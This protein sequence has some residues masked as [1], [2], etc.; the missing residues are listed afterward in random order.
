MMKIIRSS[1]FSAGN[2]ELLL[3]FAKSNGGI[4]YAR[5]TIDNLLEEA[6]QI[7]ENVSI[8]N[9]FKIILNLLVIYLKNR[10]V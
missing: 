9:E 10:I 2:I 8:D 1:D 6:E 7:I 4:E 5:K 3:D